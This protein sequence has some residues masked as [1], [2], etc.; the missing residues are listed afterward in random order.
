MGGL[1]TTAALLLTR[2]AHV[3]RRNAAVPEPAGAG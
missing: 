2:F 3:V 1:A